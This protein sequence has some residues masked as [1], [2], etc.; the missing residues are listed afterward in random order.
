[1][2]RFVIHF[3][4][5]LVIDV[6]VFFLHSLSVQRRIADLEELSRGS[7]KGPSLIT[8][9]RDEIGNANEIAILENVLGN[10]LALDMQQWLSS[11]HA[12]HMELVMEMMELRPRV[13]CTVIPPPPRIVLPRTDEED[14]EEDGENVN[15]GFTGTSISNRDEEVLASVVL[16]SPAPL[17]FLQGKRARGDDG[18]WRG[19]PPLL[20]RSLTEEWEGD[21]DDNHE[22]WSRSRPLTTFLMPPKI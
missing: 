12:S 18:I 13:Q 4:P 15:F 2:L 7:F 22:I 11:L 21:D 20:H 1:M 16:F 10:R 14:E 9:S 5:H 8:T 17:L 6:S 19:R 3:H